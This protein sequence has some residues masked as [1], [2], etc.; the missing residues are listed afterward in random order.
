MASLGPGVPYHSPA[1]SSI[2]RPPAGPQ[3][4]RYTNWWDEA[5]DGKVD[6]CACGAAACS[7]DCRVCTCELSQLDHILLSPGLWRRVAAAG[8]LHG[9]DP[10]RVSDHWPIWVTLDTSR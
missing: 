8:V 4:E 3:A 7:R 10:G 1:A 6:S 5:D 9:H 2:H